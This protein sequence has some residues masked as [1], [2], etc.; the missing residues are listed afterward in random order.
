MSLKKEDMYISTSDK[1][2]LGQ[3]FLY[4]QEQLQ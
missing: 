4:Y 1:I 2:N 3:K